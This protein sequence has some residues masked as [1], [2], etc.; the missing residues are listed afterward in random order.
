MDQKSINQRLKTLNQLIEKLEKS[1]EEETTALSNIS[2]PSKKSSK[3]TNKSKPKM[4]EEEKQK[5]LEYLA[6]R[7]KTADVDFIS[8]V[9]PLIDQ[10]PDS[11]GSKFYKKYDVNI[12]IIADEFLY[13][14]FDGVANFHYI[15][16]DN[17]K[18]YTKKLD[19]FLL[20]TAW[21]GLDMSWKGLGNPNIRKHRRDMFEIIKHYKANGIK[22]VFYSKEDPVNYDIFIELAQ[23][24]DYVFTTAEEVVENYKKDCKN[25]NVNVLNFGINPTYHNPIGIKKFKKRDEVI[26]SGSW[27]VK[28]PHRIEDT[29]RIFDGVIDNGTDLK[30]IDRNYQLKLERHFFPEKYLKYVS[31]AVDHN[32][33]QKLHKLFDWA[34][35]LNSVQKSNTMFAN[36]IYELQALGNILLSNY[37][38]GVNNKFPNVFIVNNR[39]E[40]KDILNG[41]S[42]EEKYRHQVYGIRRVM[43]RETTYSRIQ[44][45]LEITNTPFESQDRSIAVVVKSI[46]KPI[47]K[48]FNKQTYPNK[49]LILEKNL[50]EAKKAQYDMIT[51]FDSKKE[52]GEFYLEDM[53]NG[54]KYTNSDYI[55]KDAYYDGNKL[56]KGKEHDYVD[57]INDKYRTVFWSDS[58]TCNEFLNMDKPYK[59]ENG[60]SIDHF[61][62]NNQLIVIKEKAND[63][64][65]SVII[66]TYN[67]GE[68]LL[69]KCFNSLKRSSI[70]ESMEIIIVDDGSTDKYTHS[71]V[72][73]LAGKYTNIKTFFFND[74]G[75]GSASRPRNKGIEIATAPY[76]TYLDPD[77]EAINDGYAALLKEIEQGD[78]DFVVGNMLKITDKVL[79]FDYYRTMMQFNGSEVIHKRNIKQY[80]INTKFKAMSIQALVM[81]KELVTKNELKMVE[82]AIGQDTLFFQELLMNSKKVKAIN[83]DIHIYYAAV[84][85]SVTNVIS[86]DF[87]DKYLK[88]EKDRIAFLK[89]NDLLDAYMNDKFYV[90]FKNWYLKKLT[91]IKKEDLKDSI[92]SLY[93]IYSLYKDYIKEMDE[94][95]LRFDELYQNKEFDKMAKSF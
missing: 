30:I 27:Y 31:P 50:D 41:F 73:S 12:G 45:L 67:N 44:E 94:D 64:K 54:F 52:Y 77:N 93:I 14:S 3:S 95:L 87:F 57:V 56:I 2:L 55:T 70:F 10:I 74:G 40:V 92:E 5:K 26:F 21:K 62:F 1:I 91:R 38:L 17:Y 29:Q 39:S 49:E 8:K 68:H 60:Y 65:L 63:F 59:K 51:F 86:K 80:L 36:R 48:M 71:I 32:T 89:K 85:G 76:V 24:C 33:L 28:Y 82:G 34:I 75:S 53:I 19:I 6:L 37:S 20:V 13:N 46:T 88:L 61:E 84:S 35:N 18:K 7:D 16:R 83:L 58:F 22:T 81:K 43:S 25:D 66:P 47:Q 79:N 11:N 90:Y 42:D 23:K 9:Q 69:N 4:T 15:T 72:Q 78:Y